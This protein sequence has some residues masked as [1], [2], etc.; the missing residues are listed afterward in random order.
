MA[1]SALANR[2]RRHVGMLLGG[3][4]FGPLRAVLADLTKFVI[5]PPAGTGG[6]E[7]GRG[8]FGAVAA[9]ALPSG[10]AV[11]VKT[12]HDP[13]ESETALLFDFA[14]PVAARL[15]WGADGPPP[16]LPRMHGWFVDAGGRLG[17]VMERLD[18]GTGSDMVELMRSYPFAVREEVARRVVR[19][20]GAALRTLRGLGGGVRHCDIKGPNVM[21]R[22][23]R[24]GPTA[25]VE[26]VLAAAERA[27][28]IDFGGGSVRVGSELWGDW[29]FGPAIS[30]YPK[31]ECV[32]GATALRDY[33]PY[34]RIDR[35]STDWTLHN[36][37]DNPCNCDGATDG[38]GLA[39]LALHLVAGREE[40]DIGGTP[41]H[42]GPRY[43]A[44]ESWDKDGT[45]TTG[46]DLRGRR[47][48]PSGCVPR[49]S[50]WFR[51]F[52]DRVLSP[53]LPHER[54]GLGFEEVV[55]LM[56]EGGRGGGPHA[57]APDPKRRRGW[58]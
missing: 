43:D 52:V 54:G 2:L 12:V 28:L 49:A 17:L 5:R 48:P 42:C 26:A 7:L 15:A 34:N 19:A 31:P 51:S 40:A 58:W 29:A 57:D 3:P 16:P 46:M 38:V 14:V 37:A 50:P 9:A 45:G 41:F 33:L 44:R 47:V 39:T 36:T 6:R 30:T 20:L 24:L 21:F 25:P 13:D 55:R 53:R 35:N 18:G 8:T 56:E 4:A 1:E 10:E 22:G 27:V 32:L 11:V 23:P